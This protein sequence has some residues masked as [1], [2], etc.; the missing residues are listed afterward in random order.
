MEPASLALA[1]PSIIALAIQSFRHILAIHRATMNA[2][3]RLS[4]IMRNIIAAEQKFCIIIEK[5]LTGITDNDKL[6]QLMETPSVKNWSQHPFLEDGL[7]TTLGHRYSLFGHHVNN[8]RCLL[9]EFMS[10]MPHELKLTEKA[11]KFKATLR[12]LLPSEIL[13]NAGVSPLNNPPLS[14]I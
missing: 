7:R 14:L 3:K 6:K 11:V 12:P 5:V 4:D 2:E 10:E 13:A 8:I 9:E 1:V